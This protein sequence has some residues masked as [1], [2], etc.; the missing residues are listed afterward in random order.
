MEI[1][2]PEL[3][4]KK[5]NTL[6]TSASFLDIEICIENNKFKYKHYDK[7]DDFP[8][9]IVRMPFLNSNMPS[10]IFYASLGSEILRLGRTTNDITSLKY[11]VNNL[12]SRMKK[13]GAKET[14]TV[15][16]IK[17]VFGKNPDIFKA[18]SDT[19]QGF[20]NILQF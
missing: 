10:K 18:F 14:N 15:K 3:E 11:N 1:Y 17:K 6:N 16:T 12:L 20:V 9:S 2:P 5:E 8:F 19:S 13:Q 4:L 7:R